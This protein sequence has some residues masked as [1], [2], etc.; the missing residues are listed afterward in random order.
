MIFG[1]ST[2]TGQVWEPQ[3]KHR[4]DCGKACYGSY[5]AA[6]RARRAM[7]RSGKDRKYE[8]YLH[9]YPCPDCRAWHV[10][11]TAYEDE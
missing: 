2:L 6:H 7:Q 11:H 10:G 8:G 4:G 1:S 9:E 5:G 3:Q